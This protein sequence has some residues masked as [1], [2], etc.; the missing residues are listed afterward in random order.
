MPE[1]N[2]VAEALKQFQGDAQRAAPLA[3]VLGF[4]PFSTPEFGII[5]GDHFKEKRQ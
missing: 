2:E 5:K 3:S 4:K 1:L